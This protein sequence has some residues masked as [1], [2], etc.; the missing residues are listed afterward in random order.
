MSPSLHC[1]LSF[2]TTTPMN[3]LPI[4]CAGLAYWVLG[5]VWYSLLFGKIWAAEQTRFRG[6]RAPPSGGEMLT[7]MLGPFFCNLLAAGAMAYLVKRTAI[8]DLSHSLRL[9]AAGGIGFAGTA[10]T[11]SSIWEGKSTKHWIIVAGYNFVGAILV[12]MILINWP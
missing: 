7:K 10:L 5:Y 3:W 2:A 12:V 1:S 9:A 4:L 11:M 6:K 8:L